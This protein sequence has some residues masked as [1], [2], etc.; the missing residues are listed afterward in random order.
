MSDAPSL[1]LWASM[2]RPWPYRLLVLGILVAALAL[3]RKRPAQAGLIDP[4]NTRRFGVTLLG[5]QIAA[6]LATILFVSWSFRWTFSPGPELPE[7]WMDASWRFYS[8]SFSP[9]FAS[10]C[11][12]WCLSN[13]GL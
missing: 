6:L 9:N 4:L 7:S 10:Y 3:L 8:E 2:L 1:V 11:Q 5:G 13:P 12:F